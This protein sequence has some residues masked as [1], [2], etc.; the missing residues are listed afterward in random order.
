MRVPLWVAGLT[1]MSCVSASATAR[2]QTTIGS[3]TDNTVVACAGGTCGQSFSVPAT[4]S[5]DRVLQSVTLTFATSS[6]QTFQVYAFSGG[7]LTG[8]PLFTQAVSPTS[9]T[10]TRTFT[11]AGGLALVGGAQYA[12][13][14]TALGA[15]VSLSYG[16]PGGYAGGDLLVCPA[17]VCT[18][19]PTDDAAFSA[20]F[21]SAQAT[22]PEPSTWA[23]VATGLLGLG[24][25]A[26][27]R[28][29][30]S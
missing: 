4:P 5:L 28:K 20:T 9:G 24:G 1:A 29:R 21:V 15:G 16:F 13:V 12:A 7:V 2:A 19:R 23:T 14:L 17:S 27:L 30:R 26:A 6:A 3:P 22:V 8:S 10:E 18:V 11:P 25:L